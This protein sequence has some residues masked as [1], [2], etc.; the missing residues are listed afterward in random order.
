MAGP[1][2]LVETLA[3]ESLVLRALKFM[4]SSVAVF[5]TIAALQLAVSRAAGVFAAVAG[6]STQILGGESSLAAL[7]VLLRP[8]QV[9]VHRVAS[10]SAT[11]RILVLLLVVLPM[12]DDLVTES[13]PTR[14]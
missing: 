14:F 10:L 11:L 7:L 4:S 1:L 3:A 5:T 2:P 9:S 12:A 6:V 8:L 13:I